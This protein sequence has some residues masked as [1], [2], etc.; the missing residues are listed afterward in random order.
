[1][2]NCAAS[3]ISAFAKNRSDDSPK[4]CEVVFS[5]CGFLIEGFL[6]L[7]DLGGLIP[8]TLPDGLKQFPDYCEMMVVV[9]GDEIQM[10]H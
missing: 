1:M 3:L 10:V 8:S 6:V 5:E 4:S 7:D 9:F 2:L